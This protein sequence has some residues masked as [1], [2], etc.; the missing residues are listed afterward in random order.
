VAS[1][2]FSSL[3][4]RSHSGEAMKCGDQ[5]NRVLHPGI[6]IESQDG[7]EANCF[8]ACRASG[9]AK[10]PCPKCLVH[11]DQL[12]NITG[13]FEPRTSESMR[14]VIQRAS[15]ALSKTDKEKILQSFGLHDIQVYSSLFSNKLTS[16]CFYSIFSGTFAFPIHTL[17][18]AMT[19][20][21]RMT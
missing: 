20:F 19:P 2:V 7:E 12:H 17:L 14:S 11:K 16:N 9:H 5:L 4:Q 6:L 18:A 10:F 15:Q 3:R 21:I 8:C 1:R 13:S